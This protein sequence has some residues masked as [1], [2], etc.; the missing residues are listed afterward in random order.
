MG[1]AREY[2][3][4]LPLKPHT[5]ESPP[6]TEGRV[7]AAQR[8]S[9]AQGSLDAAR[10]GGSARSQGTQSGGYVTPRQTSSRKRSRKGKRPKIEVVSPVS[11]DGNTRLEVKAPTQWEPTEHGELSRDALGL[12]EQLLDPTRTLENSGEAMAMPWDFG[13]VLAGPVVANWTVS[14]GRAPELVLH[15]EGVVYVRWNTHSGRVNVQAKGPY[16]WS[17]GAG[18]AGWESWCRNVL[19]EL[20]RF[21][22]NERVAAEQLH[23]KGWNVT[24]VEICKDHV[25]IEDILHH[26]YARRLLGKAKPDTSRMHDDGSVETIYKG[27]RSTS[28]SSM[29]IYNKSKQVEDVGSEDHYVH[30]WRRCGY[31]EG[32]ITRVEMRFAGKALTYKDGPNFRD[33]VALFCP[34]ELDKVW[35]S[36]ARKFRL[37]KPTHE[38][39]RECETDER[40][41][42]VMEGTHETFEQR[43][44]EDR[45]PK[46]GAHRWR[47]QRNMNQIDDARARLFVLH[48]LPIP[49][50]EEEMD[51]L[52]R[53]VRKAE[54]WN[55]NRFRKKMATYGPQAA[56]WFQP[57][58]EAQRWITLNPSRGRHLRVVRPK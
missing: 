27:T 51:E 4:G 48:G 44:T 24:G 34:V 8:R 22:F 31:T 9:G 25:G 14:G 54:A 42:P 40:W 6:A 57:E 38:R 32:T 58:M 30:V 20:H 23:A 33:P 29:C 7:K 43:L 15:V 39:K 52:E 18:T 37:T 26:K 19:V 1:E 41:L 10:A 35:C 21:F 16:L 5:G 47:R 53:K 45:T 56:M 50:T 3:A 12:V 17:A 13:P 49:T 36:M 46:E 28:D 55:L 2:R 11:V